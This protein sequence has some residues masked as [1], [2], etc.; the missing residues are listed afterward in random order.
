MIKK[1]QTSSQ[2]I[3]NLRNEQKKSKFITDKKSISKRKR[4]S[5]SDL[6]IPRVKIPH[7]TRRISQFKSLKCTL[8]F[9]LKKNR[10]RLHSLFAQPEKEKTL[11]QETEL[12]LVRFSF[13]PNA[14][15]WVEL[16]LVARYYGVSICNFFVMLLTFDENI[17]KGS[18][19]SFWKDSK[20]QKFQN[21]EI[22]LIQLISSKRNTLFFSIITGLNTFHG[23]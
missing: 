15:D 21:S 20:N 7:L 6:W 3:R 23:F 16:R 4:D 11:Y 13:R 14:A 8:H 10:N 9:L 1:D 22:L 17:N 12:E 5:P 19:K 18:A 2:H